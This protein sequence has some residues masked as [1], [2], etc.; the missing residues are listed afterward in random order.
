MN[1]QPLEDSSWEPLY[2]SPPSRNNC[3]NISIAFRYRPG[4]PTVSSPCNPILLPHCSP[5][6]RSLQQTCMRE[7]HRSERQDVKTFW[8]ASVQ[9]HGVDSAANGQRDEPGEE[10]REDA[11]FTCFRRESS[12][13]A[14]VRPI[15]RVDLV[16]LERLSRDQED[17]L[18]FRERTRYDR[19][20]Q[21]QYL[22]ERRRGTEF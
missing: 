16:A 9:N 11:P 12:L 2:V 8:S 4:K 20:N 14:I 7:V 3:T 17:V 10:P 13:S 15:H 21:H 5:S 6:H 22:P 19:S 1:I 18:K